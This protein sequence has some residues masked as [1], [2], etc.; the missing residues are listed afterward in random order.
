[1]NEREFTPALGRFA[2]ARYI[3]LAVALTRERLWRSLAVACA[4]PRPGDVVVD[5]GC[6]TGTLLRAVLRVEPSVTAIGVD[7]DPTLLELAR[8]K[9]DAAGATAQWHAAMG[10]ELTTVVEPGSV[11]VVM[12]SLVLHQCPVAVKRAVL[13]SMHAALRPGGRLVIA[14]FGRQRSRL[15]RAAFRLVQLVDG[16]ADTQPN[17]DGIVPE[18]M[19]EAGFRD[20]REPESVS[21]VSGSISIHVARRP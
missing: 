15:M 5:V 2:P 3:D 19:V 16:A 8:R 13:D 4:A 20:V 12:S 21:T 1:M 7:P 11:D 9:L 17:A 18:L 14:D 6:G 10:D